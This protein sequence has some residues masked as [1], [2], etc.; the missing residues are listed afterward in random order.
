MIDEDRGPAIIQC[1]SEKISSRFD[2]VA[3]V[4]DNGGTIAVFVRFSLLLRR[5]GYRFAH[6]GYG[7]LQ[8]P[9]Q[10]I[11][12]IEAA[13]LDRQHAACAALSE[14]DLKSELI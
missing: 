13:E 5:P 7:L 3:T 12:L 6:P 8:S 14:F 4:C 10:I 9:Q 1:H 2:A 11:E